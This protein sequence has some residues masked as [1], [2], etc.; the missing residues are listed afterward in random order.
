M[1]K[2]KTPAY[3]FKPYEDEED[4]E[5]LI[6]IELNSGDCCNIM[7]SY[8]N[9]VKIYRPYCSN[10]VTLEESL[11]LAVAEYIKEQRKK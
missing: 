6:K 1:A 10:E 11:I 2:K 8:D 9:V 4:Q 5:N 3:I 7:S